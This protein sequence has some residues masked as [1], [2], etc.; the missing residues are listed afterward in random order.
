MCPEQY[1][2]GIRRASHRLESFVRVQREWR[3]LLFRR[4][5]NDVEEV[6]S[7]IRG[8]PFANMGARLK[9]LCFHGVV[10]IRR[11]VRCLLTNFFQAID[12]PTAD[13]YNPVADENH[14]AVNSIDRKK[15]T[16]LEVA[17]PICS[18]TIR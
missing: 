6:G 7:R 2:L 12:T 9:P 17:F 16:L 13:P 11:H 4:C 8:N 5:R 15:L 10:T 14:A 3:G 1:D 18:L